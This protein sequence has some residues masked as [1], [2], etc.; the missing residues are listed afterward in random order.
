MVTDVRGTTEAASEVRGLA[1]G[2]SRS[3]RCCSPRSVVTPAREARR[4]FT[5]ASRTSAACSATSSCARETAISSTARRRRSTLPP[6]RTC[7]PAPPRSRIRKRPP[8]A[9]T[10]VVAV[11]WPPLRRHRTTDISTA[12]SRARVRCV[13]GRSSRARR[14]HSGWASSRGRRRA[15]CAHDGI[16]VPRPPSRTP[17]AGPLPVWSAEALRAY[18]GPA[19]GDFDRDRRRRPQCTQQGRRLLEQRDD[20]HRIVRRRGT[21]LVPQGRA[22]RQR[23]DAPGGRP[24][25]RLRSRHRH[26][27]QRDGDGVVRRFAIDLDD[28]A[29]LAR[30]VLTR[31]FTKQEC[32][33]YFPGEPWPDVRRLRM[34]TPACRRQGSMRRRAR[35]RVSRDEP[36]RRHVPDP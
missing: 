17:H 5:P 29:R 27:V 10:G 1:Y 36:A 31:G 2:A 12:R 23:A 4:P 32:T 15:R 34:A 24:D 11:A 6:S 26:P 21:R 3:T 18:V 19:T 7:A 30:S 9:P 14:R 13:W 20:R 25:L 22:R 16:P 8:S 35:P 28:V 33:P